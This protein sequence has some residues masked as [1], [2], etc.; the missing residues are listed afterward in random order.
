MQ[1]SA[2]ELIIV[3][4]DFGPALPRRAGIASIFF[5]TARP[6]GPAWTKVFLRNEAGR[7]IPGLGHFFI[8]SQIDPRRRADPFQRRIGPFLPLLSNAKDRLGAG[9][10]VIQNSGLVAEHTGFRANLSGREQDVCMKISIGPRRVEKR[11]QVFLGIRRQLAGVVPPFL[12]QIQKSGRMD[13]GLD[14]NAIFVTQP[15]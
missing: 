8:G 11:C 14:G 13:V 6:F 12:V 5:Q 2:P 9:L 4:P 10:L 3:L 15:Q 7:G 1:P